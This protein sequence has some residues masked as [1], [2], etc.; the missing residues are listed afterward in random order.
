MGL[1]KEQ[2][3]TDV[4][5]V[6]KIIMATGANVE[7]LWLTDQE[8]PE[9]ALKDLIE[10]W[11][12]FIESHVYT[13]FQTQVSKDDKYYYAMQDIIERHVAKMV[14]VAMQLRTSP[15]IQ[16]DDF[17]TSVIDTSKVTE[18]LDRELQPFKAAKRRVN[19]FSSLED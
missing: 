16:I 17:T 9:K 10:R 12:L 5:G 11:L 1:F 14:G 18:K 13:R 7:S 3:I 15:V 19:F 8:D 6:N 2:E 4:I